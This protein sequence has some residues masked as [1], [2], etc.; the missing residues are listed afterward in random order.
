MEQQ[1][2]ILNQNINRLRKRINLQLM[3][4]IALI[5]LL[6]GNIILTIDSK[7]NIGAKMNNKISKTKDIL[8]SPTKAKLA[9]MDT[10][11]ADTAKK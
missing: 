2:K 1:F 7:K 11:K 4:M 10:N 5:V 9:A 8:V 3:A 6:C